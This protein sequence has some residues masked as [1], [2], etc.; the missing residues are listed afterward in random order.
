LQLEAG[1]VLHTFGALAQ[2]AALQLPVRHGSLGTQETPGDR[3]LH[4]SL[5]N[6]PH[7]RKVLPEHMLVVQSSVQVAE[8]APFEQVVPLAQGTIGPHSRHPSWSRSPQ[9]LVP[10]PRHSTAPAAHSSWQVAP[11]AP[12]EQVSPD[13]QGTAASH[14]KQLELLVAPQIR[15]AVGPSQRFSPVAHSSTQVAPHTPFEQ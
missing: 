6:C 14:D 1:G 8:Q 13:A 12:F 15:S 5:S 11:Q 3:S 4:G 10:A 2:P 9:A 7:M